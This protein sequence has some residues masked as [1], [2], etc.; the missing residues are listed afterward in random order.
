MS[1]AGIPLSRG[2]ITSDSRHRNWS[3]ATLNSWRL[4]ASGA[5]LRAFTSASSRRLERHVTTNLHLLSCVTD[6]SHIT[7]ISS[8]GEP[9][10]LLMRVDEIV[11]LRWPEISLNNYGLKSHFSFAT[12]LHRQFAQYLQTSL[13]LG[14]VSETYV[15]F[16]IS[17][18]EVCR[19]Q[20][21][22]VGKALKPNTMRASSLSFWI[23][24]VSSALILQ[25]PINV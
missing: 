24:V 2:Q 18:S 14:E 12:E 4:N 7:T 25:T 16:E 23:E 20:V 15:P 21:R 13:T 9:E 5:T 6:V 11:M 3:H 8:N 22:C 19:C 10:F 1:R 17:T